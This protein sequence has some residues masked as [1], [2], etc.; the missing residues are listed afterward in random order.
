M[1]NL[2]PIENQKKEAKNNGR[3][4]LSFSN[5]DLLNYVTIVYYIMSILFIIWTLW[6][7]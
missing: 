1:K 3:V 6:H 2:D 7:S 4:R 5:K